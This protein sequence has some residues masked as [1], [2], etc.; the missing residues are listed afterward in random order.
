MLE[1]NRKKYWAVNLF[2]T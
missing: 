2:G 1:M